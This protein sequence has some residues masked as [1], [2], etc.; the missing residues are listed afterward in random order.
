M[1]AVTRYITIVTRHAS[2]GL[3]IT[4]ASAWGF[5]IRSDV[6]SPN[7]SAAVPEHE[8]RWPAVPPSAWME[9]PTSMSLRRASI[10]YSET[11]SRGSYDVKVT[12]D[13][14]W[15]DGILRHSEVT[16]V[17]M[18]SFEFGWPF[19]ALRTVIVN[20]RGPGDDE[21]R[22]WVVGGIPSVVRTL[23]PGRLLPV[24]PMWP[25]LIGNTIVFGGI[26]WLT[27]LVLRY[28]RGRWR[29]QRGRCQ[30]CGYSL[31]TASRCPECGT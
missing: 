16:W 27:S 5:A 20:E 3:I 7:Q 6:L 8:R 10:G 9:R 30:R 14:R 25:G 4:I 24:A 19:R 21:E 29:G 31:A 13:D 2:V 23:V 11:I 26:T 28:G 15:R 17:H 22:G 1:S 12:T 18:W